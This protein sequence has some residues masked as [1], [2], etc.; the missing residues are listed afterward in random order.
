[1]VAVLNRIK[2]SPEQTLGHLTLYDG[3]ETV[4]DVVMLE[5]PD[6]N[7]QRRI[8]RI[9]AGRYKVVP[10]TSQ[11]F[12]KHFHVLGVDGRS[13]ILIHIGNYN[14]QT[15]GCLLP[16]MYFKD[17]NKDGLTDVAESR[18]ALEGLMISAPQGFKLIIN[19]DIT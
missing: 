13:L 10:R 18:K 11:K 2:E 17:I 16:G 12:G 19:D 15:V 5:L 6:K 9:P 14:T 1:M 7:N 3:L 8:S 4:C